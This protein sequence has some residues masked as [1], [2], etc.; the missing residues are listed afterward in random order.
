MTDKNFAH[1]LVSVIIP[2][3]KVEP[4]LRQCVDSVL[5]QTYT[6]FEVILVD[7]GSPD[8]CPA[9]CDE[10]AEKD[11]RV[12]VIHKENGGLSDAQN[13]GMN[14]ACGEYALF[15]DSDD[16]ISKEFLE[17]LLRMAEEY[18]LDIVEGKTVYYENALV[19]E[20]FPLNHDEY[21][22]FNNDDVYEFYLKTYQIVS[23]CNKLIKR[24]LLSEV[25][26]IR[27][28][29]SE[30]FIWFYNGVL[31]LIVCAGYCAYS[32]YY[33]RQG[34]TLS[35][36]KQVSEKH[37]TSYINIID[38]LSKNKCLVSKIR[39]TKSGVLASICLE[40]YKQAVLNGSRKKILD[41]IIFLKLNRNIFEKANT[42]RGI[43]LK[44]LLILPIPVGKRL[45]KLL[46]G[47]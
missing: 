10:Y 28:M 18:N 46:F 41:T 21:V 38:T 8:R 2:V 3:Y 43:L 6:D 36:T 20:V 29:I 31:P 33:Y 13:A 44:L 39:S 42:R 17:N 25:R 23:A 4:Y 14:I 5:A 16:F 22:F 26:F 47:L 7:D 9:I 27:D 45:F 30:D 37:Y 40:L 34:N 35:I 24:S 15:V 19:Y 1:P 32:T 12:K 11:C